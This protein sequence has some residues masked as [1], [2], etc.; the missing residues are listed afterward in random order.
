MSETTVVLDTA[1]DLTT[2]TLIDDTLTTTTTLSTTSTDETQ[3]ITTVYALDVAENAQSI[4]IYDYATNTRDTTINYLS[5]DA[6]PQSVTTI[7][8]LATGAVISTT[9]VGAEVVYFP[10]ITEKTIYPFHE[11]IVMLFKWTAG[12]NTTTLQTY[13]VEYSTD[14]V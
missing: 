3:T 5:V 10:V 13:S 7:T 12:E 1:S 2:T 11:D 4:V 6:D 8:D 9:S 14:Q